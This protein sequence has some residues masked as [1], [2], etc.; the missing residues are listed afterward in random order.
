VQNSPKIATPAK[1]KIVDN[2]KANIR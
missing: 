2:I 1:L